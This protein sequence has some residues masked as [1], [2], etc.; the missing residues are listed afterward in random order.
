MF[1]IRF[2]TCATH[3]KCFFHFDKNKLHHD[4]ALPISRKS[5][6]DGA[7]LVLH[8][9]RNYADVNHN[10]N[11]A[12]HCYAISQEIF[13]FAFQR[14]AT[15]KICVHPMTLA[16]R[17]ADFGAKFLDYIKTYKDSQNRRK[18][19]RKSRSLTIRSISQSC[20]IINIDNNF[21]TVDYIIFYDYI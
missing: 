19:W 15:L 20:I 16:G 14:L 2:S 13:S 9:E 10:G 4:R 11:L 18:V 21:K 6:T 17:V 5:I 7:I 12:R 8:K 1:L 3:G